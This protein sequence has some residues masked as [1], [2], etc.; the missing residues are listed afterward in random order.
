[1]TYKGTNILTCV[2]VKVAGIAKWEGAIC[3]DWNP[4][5]NV[6]LIVNEGLAER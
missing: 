5:G 1:M 3:Q 4:Q 6:H 2:V